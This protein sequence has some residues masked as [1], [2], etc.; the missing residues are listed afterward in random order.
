MRDW[1]WLVLLTIWGGA[2]ACA[3]ETGS[4]S[5]R[6]IDSRDQQ[7]RVG[8]AAVFLCDADTGRP[9]VRKNFQPL[10]AKGVA[11]QGF[12]DLVHAVSNDRGYFEFQGVPAGRY[13]LIAQ[14][15]AGFAGVPDREDP[16]EFVHLHG[17]TN[18]LPVESGKQADVLIRPLG[19]A[20]MT[21]IND[22][23]EEHAFL[24]L[25]T[26]PLCGDPVLAFPFWGENFAAHAIGVTLMESAKV[27]FAGLP[28]GQVHAGLFNYD[29]NPGVGGATFQV[30]N[31]GM[32]RIPI[33]ATWSNGKYDPPET[34]LPLV[35]HLE[36]GKLS[37]NELLRTRYPDE[38]AMPVENRNPEFLVLLKHG[39]EKITLEGFGEVRLLDLAA[40]DTYRELR[41]HHRQRRQAASPDNTSDADQ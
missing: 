11:V 40:A 7:I 19:T 28:D 14:S 26:A 31:G 17:V 8:H 30:V 21:L 5:G 13:R 41:N 37:L 9:L 18:D 32:A 10:G 23:E 36:A 16:S 4:I 2:S 33:Y 24:V 22:P 27:T 1:R 35:Q 38:F 39:D 29:N 6:L 25:S 15:W 3:G 34:L 12:A 20:T